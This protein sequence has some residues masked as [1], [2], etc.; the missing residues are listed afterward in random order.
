[1]EKNM[2]K[3]ADKSITVRGIH[4]HEAEKL[5]HS[6]RNYINENFTHVEHLLEYVQEPIYVDITV[7]VAKPHP[8]HIVSFRIHAPHFEVIVKKEGTELYKV[9]DETLDVATQKLV[10][11][12]DKQISLHKNQIN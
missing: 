8:H 3:I 2:S 12:K 6:I 10:E 7:D 5:S 4:E 9:I 1:M 11:H